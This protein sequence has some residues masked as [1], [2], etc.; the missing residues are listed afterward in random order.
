MYSPRA[1]SW[2]VSD[3]EFMFSEPGAGAVVDTQEAVTPL[4]PF[5]TPEAELPSEASLWV[6]GVAIW[7]L[8]QSLHKTEAMTEHYTH[9]QVGDYS[10]ARTVQEK[11]FNGYADR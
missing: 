5:N 10:A 4:T 6:S 9:F 7:A 1:G 11:L 2:G 3:G 8:W